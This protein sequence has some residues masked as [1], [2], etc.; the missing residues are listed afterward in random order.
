MSMSHTVKHPLRKPL[1]RSLA[2]TAA[3]GFVVAPLP[4]LA[5]APMASS[6]GASAVISAASVGQRIT[7]PLGKSAIIDL[8]V[9]ARDVVVANPEV[10]DAVMRTARR[11]FLLGVKTGETNVFFLDANGRQILALEIR[12]ARDTSEFDALVRR[13]VP[14]ARVQ[15]EGI[16]ESMLLTGEVPTPAAADRVMRIARQY[17]SNPENIVNM[18][19]VK[20][21]DQV[22]LRVRIVEMQ[23]SVIKQLGV[24]LAASNLLKDLLPSDWGVRFATANGFSAN[25]S[26]LGG[27]TL[28]SSFAR[29][30]SRPVTTSFLG[31]AA[32]YLNP[33]GGAG[34]GGFSQSVNPDTG[35]VTTTYGPGTQVVN[36]RTD[37]NL[38]ALERVGLARTLAEPNL[39][40]ISGEAAKFLAGGEFPVPVAQEGS[41]ISVEF[42]PFGVGLGFTPIV[43][44]PD[45]ISL[46]ISTEVSEISTAAS[47]RQPDT[48]LRDV[49][50][51]ITDTIR[52]LSIPGVQVRR[53][54]TTMEMASGKSM[55]MAG[56]IQ[57]QTRQAIE[58]LPGV[59][60]LPVI[61]NLFRSRDFQN[62]ET[63]LVVIVTPYLVNPTTMDR[64]QT[65]A[66]GYAPASDATALLLGR[67][68][69]IV[70][71]GQAGAPPQG[72]YRAPVG[73]VTP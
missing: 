12:V 34:A 20:T 69:R 61:G 11:G 49:N 40:A 65:P 73:H 47:F 32:G 66:D 50:G 31:G 24:N 37:A 64:L 6:E 58:G 10:A 5:Q 56:L 22:M 15:A 44:G 68:N 30:V 9:E 72:R 70:R 14:D 52:G 28:E 3:L 45:R 19:S 13:L 39:T 29:F 71:P 57:Q 8:P 67:F 60:D 18:M 23:R 62:N 46:K 53:A 41:R 4:G 25:G 27:S 59:K 2:L 51:Q 63:E 54:E 7:L 42:K 48:V 21:G 1:G 43:L 26:F 35:V 17:V 36:E 55:I 38:Q 33:D 16:G